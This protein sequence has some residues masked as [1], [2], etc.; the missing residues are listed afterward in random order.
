[1]IKALTAS[2]L[3]LCLATLAPAPAAAQDATAAPEVPEITLGAEDAP[4]RVIEYASFTC[5]HCATFHAEVL[6]RLKADYIDTGRVHYTYREVYFDRY[7]LWAAIVA[8]CAG[9][10]RYF[11]MADLI[12]GT[13]RDWA[14]LRD[15]AEA[16]AA[17]RRLGRVGGLED[18]Q[19]EVCLSDIDFARAMVAKSDANMRSHEV[20]GTP[21]LVIDGKTHSNM[22]YDDLRGLLDA[23]LAK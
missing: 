4:V 3:A 2:L 16:A 23:A 22:S 9:P 8:R 1:M 17:L 5:P 13:Q 18:T 15:P 7:G 12:Y 10:E 21:T 20:R 11:G 19:L 14:T 6:P